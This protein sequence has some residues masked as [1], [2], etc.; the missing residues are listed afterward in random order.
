[1]RGELRRQRK[2]HS[3][4]KS[5]E[6]GAVHWSRGRRAWDV[7]LKWEATLQEVVP[8]HEGRGTTAA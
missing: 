4:N 8:Q 7:Q 5:R 1:M 2:I 3:E 6:C